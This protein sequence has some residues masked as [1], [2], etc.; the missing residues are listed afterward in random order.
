MLNPLYNDHAATAHFDSKVD[1][2]FLNKNLPERALNDI[3]TKDE[4]CQVQ[5]R[6]TC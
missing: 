6:R 4:L 2:C 1:Q 5:T 3:K